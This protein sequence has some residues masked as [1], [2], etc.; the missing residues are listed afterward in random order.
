M[1][2]ET[3]KNMKTVSFKNNNEIKWPRRC[4]YCNANAELFATARRVEGTGYYLVA[5][6]ERFFSLKFPICKKHRLMA[7]LNNMFSWL[8]VG[9]TVI[10]LI[11]VPVLLAIIPMIIINNTIDTTNMK[12]PGGIGDK[13]IIFSYIVFWLFSTYIFFSKP[14]KL[15]R[16]TKENI[17]IQF[18]NSEFATEF[19]NINC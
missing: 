3:E 9:R 10:A 11:F 15:K 8:G 6:T 19:E 16:V 18:K 1:N 4:A 5:Y 17:E 12:G 14:V 2:Q 7:K 13:V